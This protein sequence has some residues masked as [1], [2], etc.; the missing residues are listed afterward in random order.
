MEKADYEHFHID[1]ETGE[2]FLRPQMDNE[3]PQDENEDNNY[4]LIVRV[5][6]D[7]IPSAYDEQN[8]SIIILDGWDPPTFGNNITSFVID[9]DT[10]LINVDLNLSDD[11][12]NP[13][14]GPE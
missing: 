10:S 2:V 5:T 8:I 1:P 9:E 12:A 4:T 3:N 14:P 6:D 13:A 11:S 7:G